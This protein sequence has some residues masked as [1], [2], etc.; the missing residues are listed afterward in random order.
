MDMKIE[1]R[2]ARLVDPAT[3][4][5]E[6][7]SLYIADG[8]IAA[9]G[10]APDGFRPDQTIDAK[11]LV[12]CPGLVDLSA[13]LREPGYEYRATLESEM[14]AAVAGGVTSLACPPDTDPPLDEPG[15][16]EMLKRR[17]ESLR[18]ARVYPLGALT[19][20]LRGEKIAEM[21]ELAEAGCV[22]FFQADEPLTDFNVLLQ[23]MRY[24]ATF[25][26]TVWLRPQD[27]H[28]A[29]AGVAHEGEVSTRLGL[30]PIPEVAET[31][32]LHV[33]LE[34]A[35]S[36]GARVHVARLS[37][38]R[39]AALVAAA[40]ARG[41]PVTCDVGVHHLH[42]C[43]RDAGDFNANMNLVPPL[44]DPRDRDALRRAL[45]VGTIDAVCS[46]HT[47]VDD[48]AKQVPFGEAEPGATGLELFLPLVLKWGAEMKL[49][50]AA[51]LAAATSRSA[52]ILGID[53]GSLAPGRA[54]D[55]ILFDPDRHWVVSPEALASQ[56][57]NSP[58]L[59]L[60]LVGRVATTIVDGR[61]VYTG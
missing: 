56:G 8:L 61:V 60:E 44:R 35:A 20:G 36:T 3:G 11:G 4:R 55:L 7:A 45:A 15:L 19:L 39:G 29:H 50:L 54:A 41:L 48:D 9:V 31:V 42:L 52:A 57:H 49:P 27:S 18:Q 14:Q 23:A 46:D 32:A 10:A 26:Y 28:L 40:K 6:G 47:P 59:G 1:I 43:D 33:I 51:T 34:L 17:A 21:G 2:N 16:V 25:G 37:T 13:R 12:A 22:G 53:A 24:A 58:F 30:P 38:A 5:D